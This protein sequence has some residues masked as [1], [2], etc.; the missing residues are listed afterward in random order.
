MEIEYRANITFCPLP[1]PAVIRI[2]PRSLNSWHLVHTWGTRPR[3]RHQPTP[4]PSHQERIPHVFPTHTHQSTWKMVSLCTGPAANGWIGRYVQCIVSRVEKALWSQFLSPSAPPDTLF[5]LGSSSRRPFAPYCLTRLIPENS[6][7]AV[8]TNVTLG[9]SLSCQDGILRN[10][11][12]EAGRRKWPSWKNRRRDQSG[13]FFLK[14]IKTK[15]VYVLL[16]EA[17]L[18]CAGS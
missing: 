7:F 16:K 18:G 2:R 5:F 1:S 13:M 9:R 17:E 6:F 10:K 14:N 3:E 11:P 12:C 15:V 4:Y 8:E